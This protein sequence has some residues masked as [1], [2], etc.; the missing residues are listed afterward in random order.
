MGNVLDWTWI[1][2]ATTLGTILMAALTVAC[3]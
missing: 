3:A 1:A 2:R